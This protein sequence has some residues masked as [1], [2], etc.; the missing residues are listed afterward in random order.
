MNEKLSK[1]LGTVFGIVVMILLLMAGINYS[2]KHDVNYPWKGSI[3]LKKEDSQQVLKSKDFKT[4]E[5]CRDWVNSQEKD[6]NYVK[7]WN[8]RE[9]SYHDPH[10]HNQ[11]NYMSKV[12]FPSSKDGL[13]FALV[14]GVEKGDD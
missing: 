7:L 14:F 12:K 10:R 9:D 11:K 4:V 1:F 13:N 2:K 3:F 5:D 8:Q 6:L